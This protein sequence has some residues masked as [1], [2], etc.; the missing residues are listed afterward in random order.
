MAVSRLSRIL[1]EVRL[2]LVLGELLRSKDYSYL[3]GQ[4]IEG[5]LFP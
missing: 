2:I 1:D 3:P 5:L 4:G